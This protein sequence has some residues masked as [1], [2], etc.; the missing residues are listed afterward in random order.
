MVKLY[1][2]YIKDFTFCSSNP[3]YTHIYESISAENNTDNKNN[4][5]INNVDKCNDEVNEIYI[6]YKNSNHETII[7]NH[8]A[9]TTSHLTLFEAIK[10]PVKFNIY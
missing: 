4:I 5:E 7:E 3:H 9:I 6:K 8:R 2:K 10:I 1:N